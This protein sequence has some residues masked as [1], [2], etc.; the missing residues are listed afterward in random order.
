MN[1]NA[2]IFQPARDIRAQT[3]RASEGATEE[4]GGDEADVR[5]PCQGEGGRTQR[6]RERG[7]EGVGEY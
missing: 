7:K 5:C 6:G 1:K 3:Q 4:G 2:H